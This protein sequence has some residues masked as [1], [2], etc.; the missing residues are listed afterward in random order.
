M[1]DTLHYPDTHPAAD[2]ATL[3]RMRQKF[4]EVFGIDATMND[5]TLARRYRL[6]RDGEL[7]VILR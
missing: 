4:R 1:T 7:I 3:L 2:P 6:T 5:E